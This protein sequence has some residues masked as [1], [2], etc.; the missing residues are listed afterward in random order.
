MSETV[1]PIILLEDD[2]ALRALLMEGLKESGH[3]VQD[4]ADAAG[5]QSALAKVDGHAILVADRALDGAGPNGFQ[6]ASEALE[7]Y[8]ALKVIYV[9]GTHIAIRRRVLGERE[10][11]L[12][13]PF[14]MAQLLRAVRELS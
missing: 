4:V 1:V 7:R 2:A 12:M 9:S 6:I 10:R 13:K 11:G 14:A 8:P 3:P 5:V